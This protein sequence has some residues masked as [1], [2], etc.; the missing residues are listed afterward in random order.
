MEKRGKVTRK[1]LVIHRQEKLVE[2]LIDQFDDSG[3]F[4]FPENLL[5]EIEKLENLRRG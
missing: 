5:D 2:R 4:L 1:E 3:E